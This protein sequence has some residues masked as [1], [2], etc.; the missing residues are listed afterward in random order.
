MV[1]LNFLKN[2]YKWRNIDVYVSPWATKLDIWQSYAVGVLL[3][4]NYFEQLA[5]CTNTD[6]TIVHLQVESALGFDSIDPT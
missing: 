1:D 6:T 4:D 3:Q 5:S 2:L